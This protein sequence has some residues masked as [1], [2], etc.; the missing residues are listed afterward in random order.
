M[1]VL[2]K[3]KKKK[4]SY[5]DIPGEPL[6]L[7]SNNKEIEYDDLT[8]SQKEAWSIFE[9]W[10]YGSKKHKPTLRIGGCAG[11]GKTFLI[12][13]ILQQLN[14]MDDEC[15]V[16]AY[17]GQAVNVLRQG[18]IIAK[19]IHSTFFKS[20]DVPLLNDKGE[21]MY[22]SGIPLMKTK[23]TPIKKL[24]G[25]VKL[26]IVDE[27][28]FLSESL[29][30]MIADYNVPILET[31][32]PIQ[33]PPVTGKQCFMLDNLDYFMTDVM[34]QALDSEIIDLATRIRTYTPVD[35]HSYR[36]EVHFL[37]QQD[38]PEAT[39]H[40]FKP[41]FKGSDIILSTTNKQ[42]QVYTDMYR[43]YIVKTDSP[44][45]RK[46]ERMICRKND[47]NTKLGPYPLTNGTQGICAYNVAKSDIDPVTKVYTMDFIPDH[48]PDMAFEGLL[49]DAKFLGA[50]FGDKDMSYYER[51]NPGKK[52]EYAHVI[53]V[54]A[55]QGV[56]A[57]TVMFL[58]S[59]MGH[60][61]QEYHM[62][63]RYTAVTRAKSKLYY[64]LPRSSKNP[65]WSDLTY[66]GY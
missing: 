36:N 58:D 62:R 32:D 33:L 55:S 15:Y 52:F 26:I 25:S 13:F 3:P 51:L 59:F 53:T 35:I 29:Q 8:R 43:K 10:Y 30:D 23:F 40:R 49:C 65:T 31:G 64:V 45:P 22:R 17:T 24:P 6:L 60:N 16:V 41:F 46:G 19:T 20:K 2:K 50:P 63:L 34:R 9:D 61:T 18:G 1:A 5:K 37:W 12:K 14:L 57:N 4:S 47:W 38:A 54:H 42:R 28:S 44:Y 7:K 39:F 27:A 66:G 48:T 56:T 21:P 11:V